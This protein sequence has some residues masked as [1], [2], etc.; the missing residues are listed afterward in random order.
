VKR[1]DQPQVLATQRIGD[2]RKKVLGIRLLVDD[3]SEDSSEQSQH[4]L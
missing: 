3:Q 4:E 1:Q 2:N